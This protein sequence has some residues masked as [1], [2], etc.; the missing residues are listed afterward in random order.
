MAFKGTKRRT[1]LQI[2][3]AIEDVGGYINAYTSREMTAYYARVLRGRRAAGAGRDRR[4]R[5]EPGVRP[6]RDRG[7]ARRDP[8]GD[9]P[10][11]GHARRHHLRLVAGSGLSR[12]A[13][14]PHDPWARPSGSAAFARDDLAGFRG[15]AL[16]P[17]ADD[18]VGGR[19]GRSRRDRAR[20]PN[21][22]LAHLPAVADRRAAEPARFAGGERR[23]VKALEQVH[24]ALAF[25]GP[26]YRDDGD[27][28]RADLCHRAGRR[29]VV[30]AVSGNP[31]KARAVLHDLCADRR[32]CRHRHDDD[33]CRHQRRAD[34]RTGRDHHRRD[35]A[36]RRRHERRQRSPARG[37]R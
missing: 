20:W 23:Q 7:R 29:H 11:A 13:A 2:A 19:G 31:R 5:A 27:L 21:G 36:R 10:G 25:E 8:A 9:R 30:A 26:G 3:E 12:P 17:G 24:F 35:E 18:P 6:G 16:R 14:G 32:L 34:R 37:R 4:H 1:A 22:C 33:L 15:R 28:Y